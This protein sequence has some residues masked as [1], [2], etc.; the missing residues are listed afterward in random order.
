LWHSP[1]FINDVMQNNLTSAAIGR[2]AS[3]RMHL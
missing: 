3:W 1:S 2:A